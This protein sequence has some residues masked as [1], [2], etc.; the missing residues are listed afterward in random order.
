MKNHSW[1]DRHGFHRCLPRFNSENLG[2]PLRPD[3]PLRVKSLL[4]MVSSICFTG[5]FM[6][7]H[8]G[9]LKAQELGRLNGWDWREV[10]M[11]G[12]DGSVF[13][14]AQDEL[15]GKRAV[16]TE[17]GLSL[18][19]SADSGPVMGTSP[20]RFINVG[21]VFDLAFDERG[22]LWAGTG[23]GLWFVGLDGQSRERAL[24]VGDSIRPIYRVQT[25]GL[26]YV[27]VGEGGVFISFGGDRWMRAGHPLPQGPFY[28][29]ALRGG[30]DQNKKLEIWATGRSDVWKI[31]VEQAAGALKIMSA[32]RVRPPGRP[33]DE[34]PVDLAIDVHGSE[35]VVLYPTGLAR[36]LPA[37]VEGSLR[38]E[39]VFPVWLPGSRA[40][41]L[42]KVG[43]GLWL[44]TDQGLLEA[45]SWPLRWTR[46]QGP[47]GRSP[48]W[49]MAK[50][51]QQV[52]VA[53]ESGLYE[54][55]RR[56]DLSSSLSI[57]P[58]SEPR[59][60][61][62]LRTIQLQALKYVGLRPD[63][64]RDLKKGL[65]RRAWWPVLKIDAGAAYDRVSRQDQDQSFTYGELHNLRDRGLARSRDF[66]ASVSL[67][68]DLSDLAYPPEA[69]ELSR[70]AR[71]RMSL[72]DNILDEVNQLY[73]DRRR[74]LVALDAYGD[75]SDP[76]AVLLQLRAE[77]LAA[78]LDAWTGGWFSA[79]RPPVS[80]LSSSSS[81]AASHS[82]GERA[83][84]WFLQAPSSRP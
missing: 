24:G 11:E 4:L 51:G 43:A 56:A 46:T 35:V 58:E 70:E 65:S 60:Q 1:V 23:R 45:E 67:S 18:L 76:E 44:I 73:F 66:E 41:R 79:W 27:A 64:F 34:R 37:Q 77:E 40:R 74:T 3:R 42:M 50:D 29:A 54:G 10:S 39:S 78:G 19:S 26:W 25:R 9:V 80:S 71:Q 13:S 28:S 81:S 69:P 61:R 12:L 82:E 62:F 63:Y 49:D 48:M 5:A 33:L 72:R 52:L 16:G 15:R 17:H 6:N 21:R 32:Q 31:Q 38:W 57:L 59:R 7:P 83:G 53:G 22:G 2:H 75:K 36:M 55:H 20:S 47:P 30:M 8:L 14:V 68:W 84:D